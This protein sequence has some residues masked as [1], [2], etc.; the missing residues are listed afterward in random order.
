MN[1]IQWIACAA[2]LVLLTACGT[3]P[4]AP[5]Q[6][7][8]AFQR[9]E[10]M[11]GEAYAAGNVRQAFAD[12]NRAYAYAER[13]DDQTALARTQLNR[14]QLARR[15]LLW[16]EAESAY[17]EVEQIAGRLNDPRLQWRAQLGHA[18]LLRDRGVWNH[19]A[20]VYGVLIGEPTLPT[21][22][23][24]RLQ[25]LIGRSLTWID[26]GELTRAQEDLNAAESLIAPRESPQLRNAYLAAMARLRAAQ[27]HT[28]EALA[29]ANEVL[30]ADKLRV[31]ANAVA[32]DLLLL[33]ELHVM[34]GNSAQA[35]YLLARVGRI[36]ERSGQSGR[37]TRVLEKAGALPSDPVE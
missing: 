22:D 26:Q 31:D 8:L 20:T 24:I 15:L 3:A 28:D 25:S 17:T 27:G 32:D 16:E 10:R 4:P 13:L 34:A 12:F 30:E 9:A 23:P 37:A 11:A 1:R 35:R 36:Y 14:A 6:P 19:A 7:V 33:A 2:W 29:M 5:P 18:G 21:S